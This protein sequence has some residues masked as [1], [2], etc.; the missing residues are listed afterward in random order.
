MIYRW[1]CAIIDL[2]IN[3]LRNGGEFTN[4]NITTDRQPRAKLT[5]ISCFGGAYLVN[6]SN[7]NATI[8]KFPEKF[9]HPFLHVFIFGNMFR[10][11]HGFVAVPVTRS[12]NFVTLR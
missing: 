11:S 5:Q 2:T 9:E 1:L 4:V 10:E 8:L 3:G 6:S 7:F 12:N